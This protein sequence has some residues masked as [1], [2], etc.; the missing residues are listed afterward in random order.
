MG[1]SDGWELG[2]WVEEETNHVPE[3]LVTVEV[4]C[5]TVHLEGCLDSKGLMVEELPCCFWG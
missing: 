1:V 5:S 2:R 4:I 3:V